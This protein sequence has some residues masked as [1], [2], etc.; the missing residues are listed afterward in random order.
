VTL[1][2]VP[3][4]LSAFQATWPPAA[5]WQDAGWTIRDGACGGKR[6]AAA[7]QDAP[8][9]DPDAAIAAMRARGM[10]PLFMV[11]A[12]EDALDAALAERG[13]GRIDPTLIYAA[14]VQAIAAPP[15]PVRLFDIWPPMAIMRELWSEGGTGPARLAVMTRAASPRTS[16]VARHQDKAAGVAF[17]A[18]HDGIAMLHAVEVAPAARRAGLGRLIVKGAA[19]WAAQQGAKWFGLAVTEANAPARA[20]YDG[21]GMQLATRY[22]YRLQSG[23]ST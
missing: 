21:L 12:G 18:V 15:P 17:C 8:D 5:S 9:A 3:A 7:T 10:D 14:T 19:H 23:A 13:F 20:L 4:L 1:P 16:F 22:H 6:V 11:R 2:A